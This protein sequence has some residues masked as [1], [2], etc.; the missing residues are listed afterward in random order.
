M[1]GETLREFF[2][3]IWRA[4]V[5]WLGMITLTIVADLFDLVF[6]HGQILGDLAA[7]SVIVR[8]FGVFWLAAVL[9]R[10]TME[11]PALAWTLDGGFVFFYFWQIGLLVSEAVAA[12]ML[13]ILKNM[14]D[15]VVTVPVNPYALTLV[16]VALSTPIIDLTSLRLA[17]W[18]AGRTAHLPKMTFRRAWR[19][20]RG[21]WREAA[22]TYLILVLPLFLIHYVLT[23]WIPGAKIA[24][25]TK[26][27]WTL[28]DSVESIATLVL[29]LSLYV[30]CFKH[31]NAPAVQPMAGVESAP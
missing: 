29:L 31:V 5:P 3:S 9:L 7:V 19:E 1:T 2:R 21:S 15:L 23:V 13:S 28:F 17:P 8:F 30:A 10:R 18:A 11:N 16:F 6:T 22:K 20:M 26:I 24:Q 4:P 14:L 25:Q 27:G 12:F